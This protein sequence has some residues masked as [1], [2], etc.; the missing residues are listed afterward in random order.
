M[1]KIVQMPR[2]LTSSQGN[3]DYRT[4]RTEEGEKYYLTLR[5]QIGNVQA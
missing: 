5:L 1:I 3:K 4:M 2:K